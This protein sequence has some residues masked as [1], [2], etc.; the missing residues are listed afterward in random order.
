MAKIDLAA[1]WLADNDPHLV[2]RRKAQQCGYAMM[3][4][5]GKKFAKFVCYD[6]WDEGALA[7]KW[8]NEAP[9]HSEES[10]SPPPFG[11]DFL[12]KNM[13]FKGHECLYMPLSDG[14]TPHSVSYNG[15]SIPAAR[16]M[17]IMVHG[18]PENADDVARHLCGFGHRSCV[19]PTHLAWGS[20]EQNIWDKEM[21]RGRP[22]IWPEVP[23]GVAEEIIADPRMP[24]VLAIQ[25]GVHAEIIRLMKQGRKPPKY[26]WPKKRP[27]SRS[28]RQAWERERSGEPGDFW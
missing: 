8:A 23:I 14:L 12:R 26:P 28:E 16:L 3:E 21:H 17:C 18:L 5:R 9:D 13:R 11:V 24:N 22:D 1:Q 7:Q 25:Y 2:A 10:S 4:T 6:E 20:V 15:A 19:N 27:R